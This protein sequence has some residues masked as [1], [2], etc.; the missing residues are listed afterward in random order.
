M[1]IYWGII[2]VGDK[3]KVNCYLVDSQTF[4]ITCWGNW[5]KLNG[6]R[7]GLIV[8]NLTPLGKKVSSSLRVCSSNFIGLH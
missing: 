2:L 3:T 4:K 6:F 5:G 1:P 8:G 7:W